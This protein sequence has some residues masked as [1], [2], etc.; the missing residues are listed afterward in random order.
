[1]GRLKRLHTRIMRVVAR[2]GRRGSYLIFIALLDMLYGYSLIAQQGP[3]F[4]R[5]PLFLPYPVWGWIWIGVAAICAW[6]AFVRIDRIG[7]TAAVI[8][9]FV[10]GVLALYDWFTLPNEPRGWLSGVIWLAFAMLTAIVSNWPEHTM[11]QVGAF[12][13]D[14]Q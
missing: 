7:Y 4:N 10:W 12:N 6:Q 9:K 8:L 14:D 3:L 2:I 5:A 11:P 1:M 13:G